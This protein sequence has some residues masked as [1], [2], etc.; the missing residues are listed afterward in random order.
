MFDTSGTRIGENVIKKDY[1]NC[2]LQEKWSSRGINRGTSLNYFDP[3]DSTWNQL[4]VDN[5]GGILKLKGNLVEHKMVLR[6]ALITGDK[7]DFYYN[8]ISWIPKPDGSVHQVWEVYDDEHHLL[9]TAFHGVYT[10]KL[11]TKE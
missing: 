8:Q 6:S 11:K 7:V 10:R 1:D 9:Q 3:K 2:L 4:W 5:Q